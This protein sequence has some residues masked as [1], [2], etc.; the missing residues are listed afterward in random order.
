MRI[1]TISILTILLGLTAC[2]ASS[3]ITPDSPGTFASPED[4][5]MAPPPLMADEEDGSFS[6]LAEEA[7]EEEDYFGDE[8]EIVREDELHPADVIQPRSLGASAPARES[9][10]APGERVEPAEIGDVRLQASSVDEPA[11]AKPDEADDSA[12]DGIEDDTTPRQHP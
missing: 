7:E 10:I 3:D 5:K 1:P 12:R 9:A 11:Q 6:E 2:G 8:R 4:M